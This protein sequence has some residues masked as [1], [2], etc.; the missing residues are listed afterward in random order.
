V[1]RREVITLLGGAAAA[2]PLASRAQQPA[3]PMIGYLHQTSPD[4]DSS[5]IVAF[6]Q[7]LRE[8]GYVEGLNIIIEGRPAD[9]ADQLPGLAVDLVNLKVAVIVARG[10]QAVRAAQQ[11]TRTIP[12]VMTSSDPVGAGFVASLAR[13]GGNTTGVSLLSPE[14][15][16]KR[17]QLIKEIVPGI[18]LVA[19]LWNPDDPPALTALKETEAAAAVLGIKVE[20]L[21]VRK[22]DDFDGAFASA[23]TVRPDA[24]ILLGA[25]IM[26][27]Y[28]GRIA[29]FALRSKLP[30]I[31]IQRAFPQAG[32]L[33]SYG[34]SFPDQARRAAG[35][36][37]KILKGAKPADLPVEQPTR[38]ELIINLKT[39]KTLGLTIPSG[40]LAIADEVIE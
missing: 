31:D 39:A 16:G 7:G 19:V 13:P 22:P 10:S 25:P 33:M 9:R 34:P 18:A 30:A 23:T 21:A 17:L 29:D 8:A 11:A 6:R 3:M 38:F 24:L 20:A 32:G 35:Y 28:A 1:R 4:T 14:L 37:A 26:S 12:I 36:V 15:S 27:I 2:W 40:V 5:N